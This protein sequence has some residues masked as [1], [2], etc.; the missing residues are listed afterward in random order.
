MCVK[1][2]NLIGPEGEI[3]GQQHVV[4]PTNTKLKPL[5]LLIQAGMPYTNIDK[6]RTSYFKSI[7]TFLGPVKHWK[8]IPAARQKTGNCCDFS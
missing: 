1:L 4:P 5:L 6:H 7:L 3:S 8:S 2:S